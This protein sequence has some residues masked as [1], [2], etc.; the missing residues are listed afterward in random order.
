M[1]PIV[2]PD[3]QRQGEC[4]IRGDNEFG[5]QTVEEQLRDGTYICTYI[6][7][8]QNVPISCGI[9]SLKKKCYPVYRKS[10]ESNKIHRKKHYITET[11]ENKTLQNHINESYLGI[12]IKTWR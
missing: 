4:P 12:N 2:V 10:R 8:N 5:Q 3:W 11:K 6:L 7:Y 1:W 9:V